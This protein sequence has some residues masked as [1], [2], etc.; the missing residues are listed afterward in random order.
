M[1]T[2][3]VNGRKGKI[4]KRPPI[5]QVVVQNQPITLG[6][7]TNPIKEAFP[8]GEGYYKMKIVFKNTLT[9][10]TGTTPIANALAKIL[11]NLKIKTSAD[12]VIMDASGVSFQRRLQRQIRTAARMSTLAASNGTYYFDLDIMFYNPELRR[13]EDTI[14]NTARYKS[15]ELVIT[16]GTVADLLG[17]VGTASLAV[18]ADV[19]IYKSDLN[20]TPSNAPNAIP[21][22]VDLPT[23]LFQ[24]ADS[25]IEIDKNEDLAIFNILT[26]LSDNTG[27]AG[28]PWSGVEQNVPESL[29]TIED[30]SHPFLFDRI[31]MEAM[32]S[33][34]VH[35]RSLEAPGAG[36]M[37]FNMIDDKSTL[38]ALASGDKSKLRVKWDR[39]GSASTYLVTASIDGIKK[40]DNPE[41]GV[42]IVEG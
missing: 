33:D 23:K 24:A 38:S 37:C 34:V 3:S 35:E 41:F 15:L 36:T 10:G 2:V 8:L 5:K 19:Y 22:F 1:K 17:T 4:F 18:T 14:L 21:Y 39:N 27:T 7:A 9:V 31:S 12:G 6:G 28:I 40:L 26:G 20:V 42:M 16:Y 13:P 25:Y 30:N 11:K 32:V 29:W